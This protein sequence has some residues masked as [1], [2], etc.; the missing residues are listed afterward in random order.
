MTQLLV[1]LDQLVN[2][3]IPAKYEGFGYA[4][5]TLSARAWRLRQSTAWGRLRIL[6]DAVFFWEAD[7]CRR[8]FMAECTRQQLPLRYCEPDQ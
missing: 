7:H 3:L 8:A 6:I 2:T 1:A 4:D 5:E